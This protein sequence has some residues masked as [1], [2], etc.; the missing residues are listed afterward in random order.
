VL[1]ALALAAVV[2]TTPMAMSGTTGDAAAAPA[3]GTDRLTRQLQSSD[4]AGLRRTWPVPDVTAQG[5]IVYDANTDEPIAG[6][7]AGTPRPIAS[8]VKLM[9]ALVVV[10]RVDP[11]EQ[12]TI[13]QQVN[14]LGADAARM[15]ARAGE[16]WPASVLLRAMLAHSANDAAIALARHVAADEAAFVELMNRRARRLGLRDTTFTSATGL[17]SLGRSSTSTPL[18]IVVLANAAFESPSIAAALVEPQLRLERPGGGALDP[19]PNRNP[20]LGRYDGV[21]AGKTGF[22]DAAGYMLVVHHEDDA[23]GGELVVVTFASTSEQTRAADARALLDWARPLR[24]RL[25]LV[26]GG[27]PLGSV[28]VQRSTEHVDVFA[29]DDLYA[30]VRVGQRVVHEVVLPRSVAA[31]I[32]QGD[33]LGELRVR[34]GSTTSIQGDQDPDRIELGTASVPICAAEDVAQLRG[35]D[36][37]ADRA[38][39]WRGAW[40]SG[41]D[42]VRSMWSTLRENAAA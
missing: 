19:L 41:V 16:T 22:T 11:D 3:A 28:P 27:T 35:W 34:S 7:G 4:Q 40:R 9:T 12:V 21:D 20:L 26:E 10:D 37:F 2:A 15:D 18:D 31:P 1:A 39:D 33:E 32:A 17:D 29:C 38:R 25:L 30:S 5:W 13:P 42:E 14:D 24:Q 6:T 23:T 36:R 8:L